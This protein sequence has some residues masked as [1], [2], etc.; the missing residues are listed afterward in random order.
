[1]PQC[2]KAIRVCFLKEL[3]V[4]GYFKVLYR[5]QI[6]GVNCLCYSLAVVFRNLYKP[7][8]STVIVNVNNRLQ[9]AHTYTSCYGKFVTLVQSRRELVVDLSCSCSY[10]A[11]AFSNYN[12]IRRT[13]YLLYR[14][15]FFCLIRGKRTVCFTV[16]HHNRRKTAAAEARNILSENRPSSVVSPSCMPR[17]SIIVFQ[18]D[19]NCLRDTQY[20]YTT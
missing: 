13:P 15:L 6:I 14:W 16:N 20:P 12:F 17:V 7:R 11:A 4:L 5:W 19:R 1:M 3:V 2:L 18:L 9:E 10:T 8:K